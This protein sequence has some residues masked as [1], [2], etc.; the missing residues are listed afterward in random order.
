MMGAMEDTPVSVRTKLWTRDQYERLVEIGAFAP[1]ERVQLI[2]GEIVEMTPQS[3]AHA[4][5]IEL[6]QHAL[7]KAVPALSVRVQSPLALGAE[8]EPEPD[9]AVVPGSP[10]TRADRHPSSAVLVVEIADTTLTFDRTRKQAIYAQA[11]IPDYWI[12]NLVERVLEV[13]REPEGPA[14][15]TVLRL[16]VGETIAPIAVPTTRIAVGDLLP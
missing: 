15:R 16:S 12:V 14:Y 3:A 5:A 7:H 4:A 8:S 13:Y 10:R 11:R 1:E 9:V 6:V 2:E